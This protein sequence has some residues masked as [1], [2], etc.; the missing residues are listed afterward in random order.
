MKSFLCISIAC[1]STYAGTLDV[2]RI[3]KSRLLLLMMCDGVVVVTTIDNFAHR[4]F[5]VFLSFVRYFAVGFLYADALKPKRSKYSVIGRSDQVR[6]LY[7]HP[8]ECVVHGHHKICYV[9]HLATK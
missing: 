2:S 8:Y 9:C 3:R 6:I 4:F 5:F 1:S 7:V